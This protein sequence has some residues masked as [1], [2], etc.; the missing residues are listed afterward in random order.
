M[1]TTECN[2]YVQTQK[3]FNEVLVIRPP[4][5]GLMGRA[6]KGSVAATAL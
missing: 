1:A 4:G 6:F 3:S 5:L 2:V